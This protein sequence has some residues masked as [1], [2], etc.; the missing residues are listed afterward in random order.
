MTHSP[1]H[2]ALSDQ[3]LATGRDYAGRG[4]PAV[5]VL[6]ATGACTWCGCD[7]LARD[8]DRRYCAGCPRDAAMA[9]HIYS[10]ATGQQEQQI[11]VCPEHK[12]DC[13]HFIAAVVAAGGFQ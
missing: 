9:L 1:Q 2:T 12:E 8:H 5:V 11:P 13:L 6:P 4:V 10:A 7:V 3:A